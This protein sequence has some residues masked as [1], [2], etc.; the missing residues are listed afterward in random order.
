MSAVKFIGHF[1]LTLFLP[2][3]CGPD[4]FDRLTHHVCL[5]SAYGKEF[6]LPLH[7]FA[8]ELFVNFWFS[9]F[10]KSINM[11][12]HYFAAWIPSLQTVPGH[13]PTHG[14]EKVRAQWRT[15]RRP[16][17]ISVTQ[18]IM[19]VKFLDEILSKHYRSGK[20]SIHRVLFE[21]QNPHATLV[22]PSSVELDRLVFSSSQSLTIS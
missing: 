20:T 8:Y 7:G 10:F 13:I 19:H 21:K 2:F 6:W 17:I 11:Y 22:Q 9:W 16:S 14:H 12:N 18:T 15:I 1:F 4:W 3:H 5:Q